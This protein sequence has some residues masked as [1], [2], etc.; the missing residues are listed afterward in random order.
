MTRGLGRTRTTV[1]ME[2]RSIQPH[3]IPAARD[4]LL[5]AGWDRCVTDPDEFQ[6]LVARSQLNLVAVEHNEVLGFL[7]A[8]T[9]GMANGYISMV[10]VA[11]AHRGKGIGRALTLAAMGH[12]RRVT[13]VLRA[14]RPEV[15]GFYSKLGFV[16]S[17]VAMERPGAAAAAMPPHPE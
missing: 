6:A 2:I 16:A 11:E 12:D 3:E 1:V 7:R 17:Q 13:W 10:V 15:K 9:D 4:L 14:A 5:A 8:L